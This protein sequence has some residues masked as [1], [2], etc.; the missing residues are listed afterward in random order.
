M[1]KLLLLLFV[2]SFGFGLTACDDCDEAVDDYC[3]CVEDNQ[4][5]AFTACADELETIDD[6]CDD[7][8]SADGC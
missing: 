6:E 4:A 3:A 8:D 5:N 1:K 7:G 2:A